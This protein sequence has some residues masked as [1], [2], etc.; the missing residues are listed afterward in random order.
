M[1]FLLLKCGR[2]IIPLSRGGNDGFVPYFHPVCISFLEFDCVGYLPHVL[3]QRRVVKDF[4][5][6]GVVEGW[7]IGLIF[8]I[9]KH[10]R[11]S[12][13]KTLVLV[14]SRV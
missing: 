6:K 2:M 8:K 1:I 9:K 3:N 4:S 11:P 7:S 12:F 10:F 14:N 13:S 5:G